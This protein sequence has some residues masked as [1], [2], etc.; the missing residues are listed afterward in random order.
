MRTSSHKYAGPNRVAGPHSPPPHMVKRPDQRPYQSKSYVSTHA[1]RRPPSRSPQTGSTPIP[2]AMAPSKHPTYQPREESYDSVYPQGSTRS[3][4]HVSIANTDGYTLN[5]E[6]CLCPTDTA[7]TDRS[8][9]NLRSPIV[10]FD[11]R[12][13]LAI[14]A[15]LTKESRV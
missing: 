6:V 10:P 13:K 1:K 8:L 11:M 3:E 14:A 12:V 9:F 5:R 2:K 15:T 4:D 7:L